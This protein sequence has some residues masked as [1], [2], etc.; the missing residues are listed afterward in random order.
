MSFDRV[1]KIRSRCS[2]YSD[3]APIT[4]NDVPQEVIEYLAQAEAKEL[5]K[6]NLKGKIY[7]K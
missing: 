6:K 3:Y 4:R 1:S 5:K 2:I 7:L